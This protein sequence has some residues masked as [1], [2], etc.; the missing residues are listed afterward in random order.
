[1]S[2]LPK[3]EIQMWGPFLQLGRNLPLVAQLKARCQPRGCTLTP[4]ISP[5]IRSKVGASREIIQSLNGLVWLFQK[6]RAL[7]DHLK[8]FSTRGLR[9]HAR[10]SCPDAG[11]T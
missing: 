10:T 2:F 1:M 5:Q 3:R 8:H 11:A 9:N 6:S 7:R 4:A